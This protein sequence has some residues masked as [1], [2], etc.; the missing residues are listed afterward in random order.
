M[1]LFKLSTYLAAFIAVVSCRP[2]SDDSN[3]SDLAKV[4][5][6]VSVPEPSTALSVTF[7]ATPVNCDGASTA[8]L[9]LTDLGRILRYSLHCLL[10]HYECTA[11]AAHSRLVFDSTSV[12][13]IAAVSALRVKVPRKWIPM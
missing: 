7:V 1:K 4:N 3:D 12:S 6:I 10:M 5:M 9:T 11:R 8:T 2:R 13:V